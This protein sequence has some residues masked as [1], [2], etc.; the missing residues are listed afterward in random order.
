MCGFYTAAPARN[1]TRTFQPVKCRTR[2]AG[3]FELVTWR[4]IETAK[5]AQKTAEP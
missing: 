3:D 1:R 2:R 4:V 5:S